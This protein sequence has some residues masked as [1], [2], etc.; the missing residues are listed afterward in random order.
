MKNEYLKKLSIRAK[1]RAKLLLARPDFQEE[2]V[3]IRK[4]WNIPVNG[5]KDDEV[6][7]KWHD[8]YYQS[9]EEYFNNVMGKRRNEV[10]KLKK[11]GKYF[12][13]EKI[14]RELNNAAPINALR[15]AIKN[16][17]KKYKIPL[18]WEHAVYRYL[19]F[20]DI[21]N[22]MQPIGI[23]IHKEIDNEID[24]ERMYIEIEDS[25]TLEDIKQEWKTIKYHQS[26]LNAHVKKKFQ[27]IKEFE[28]DKRAYELHREG[29]SLK[30]VVNILSDETGEVYEW[31]DISKFIERHRK[32][33]GIN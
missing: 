4:K 23:S 28:R 2:I 7:Q 33:I 6:N 24:L 1:Q 20:N 8:W 14:E 31:Y 9:D 29:K 10:V 19:L 18:S 30:E 25:T 11:D 22:M 3:E 26:K 17:L 13:A 5:L 15:I 27:P 12:E 21:D 16:L 32:K